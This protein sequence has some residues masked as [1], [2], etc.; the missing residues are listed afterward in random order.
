MRDA[1]RC[2][3]ALQRAATAILVR[4][5]AVQ[6]GGAKLACLGHLRTHVRLEGGQELFECLERQRAIL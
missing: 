6:L 2:D 4:E 1:L 3:R 5:V